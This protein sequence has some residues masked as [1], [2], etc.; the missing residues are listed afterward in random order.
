MRHHHD[1][2]DDDDNDNNVVNRRLD[3][4][5]QHERSASVPAAGQ[6]R[7]LHVSDL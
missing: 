6:I 7:S 5:S 1:D 4:Y 3:V 2:D